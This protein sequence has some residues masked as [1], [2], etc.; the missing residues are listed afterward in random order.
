MET[1]ELLIPGQSHE[2]MF[3]VGIL[4]DEEKKPY[5]LFIDEKDRGC[6]SWDDAVKCGDL[7]SLDEMFLIYASRNLL[8]LNPYYWSST[9][10]GTSNAWFFVFASGCANNT[11]LKTNAYYVRCVRRLMI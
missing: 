7:P 8:D 1:K 2:E 4:L 5:H 6:M 3:Y 11:G 9:E 10:N